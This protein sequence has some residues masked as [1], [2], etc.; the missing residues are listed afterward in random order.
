MTGSRNNM[1]EERRRKVKKALLS[2]TI[3]WFL[4]FF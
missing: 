1:S 4:K 3:Y 2:G